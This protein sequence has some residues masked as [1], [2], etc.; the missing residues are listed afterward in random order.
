MLYIHLQWPVLGMQ[1]AGHIKC[2]EGH[3]YSVLP[4]SSKPLLLAYFRGGAC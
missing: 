4:L 3:V 2:S 1:K